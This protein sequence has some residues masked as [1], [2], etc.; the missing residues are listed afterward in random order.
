MQ[1]KISYGEL[2]VI[3][4]NSTNNRV[5]MG[6]SSIFATR[7]YNIQIEFENIHILGIRFDKVINLS[8]FSNPTILLQSILIV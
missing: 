3:L 2:F 1:I 8:L 6:S 7:R 4:R 5:A